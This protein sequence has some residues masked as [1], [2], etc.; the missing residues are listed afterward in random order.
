VHDTG[1]EDLRILMQNTKKKN[2]EN[3]KSE[4]AQECAGNSVDKLPV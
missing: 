1:A 3:K 2:G 4:K